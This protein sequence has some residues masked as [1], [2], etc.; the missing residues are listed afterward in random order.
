M[1]VKFVITIDASNLACRTLLPIL[2]KPQFKDVY[3]ALLSKLPAMCLEDEIQSF[4][5]HAFI[6]NHVDKFIPVPQA[7][8]D[9][10]YLA[11]RAVATDVDI[12]LESIMFH[13]VGVV[14]VLGG[15]VCEED[16]IE[17]PTYTKYKFSGKSAVQE[18]TKTITQTKKI[19]T[20]ENGKV[21]E[22]K[23]LVSS[24]IKM[25]DIEELAHNG[26]MLKFEVASIDN[27]LEQPKFR[28]RRRPKLVQ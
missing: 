12:V 15:G 10:L 6:R 21:F 19:V 22:I 27:W 13:L 24:D 28:P 14:D 23:D 2:K 8:L 4:D 18:I 20:G 5:V 11:I 16:G 1:G 3:L 7:D 9:E 26:L 17:M 25:T